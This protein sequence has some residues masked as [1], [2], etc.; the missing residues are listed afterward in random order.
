MN[1]C[2][3]EG[4]AAKMREN[5]LQAL[6]MR[7]AEDQMGQRQGLEGSEVALEQAPAVTGIFAQG[8]RF[9]RHVGGAE[10]E[11]AGLFQ[12]FLN[13][14]FQ[15]WGDAL[16]FLQAPDAQHQEVGVADDER[17]AVAQR[18]SLASTLFLRDAVKV[19]FLVAPGG[20]AGQA[21]VEVATGTFIDER[22]AEALHERTGKGG[23]AARF[24]TGG[25]EQKGLWHADL[26]R[27]L[28]APLKVTVV[29]AKAG[30]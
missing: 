28:D 19:A 29:S 10:E 13:Q 15:I 20:I 26:G 6:F 1:F 30:V 7:A 22:S 24:G 21:A 25:D 23:F 11:Q 4:A 3:D 2:S 9:P 12:T 18:G 8:I 27:W 16:V 14:L 5:G 17:R